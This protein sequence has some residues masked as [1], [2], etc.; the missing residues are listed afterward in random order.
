MII[1]KESFK[2]KGKST[3]V[4]IGNIG[5]GT[6]HGHAHCVRF[7]PCHPTKNHGLEARATI[8]MRVILIFKI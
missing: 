5:N 3:K 1:P 6:N 7:W 8:E 4:Q 2:V